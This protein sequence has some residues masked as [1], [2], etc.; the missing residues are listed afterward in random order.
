MKRKDYLK[1]RK[2]EWV[3]N[4]KKLLQAAMQDKFGEVGAR[5]RVEA[6]WSEEKETI[7]WAKPSHVALRE[8]GR[9]TWVTW[10]KGIGAGL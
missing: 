7:A 1:Q 9:R 8:W 2:K 10:N 5:Q 4:E 6:E 3:A